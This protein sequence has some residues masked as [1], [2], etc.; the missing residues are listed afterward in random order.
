MSVPRDWPWIAVFVLG[1]GLAVAGQ[2][3]L[4]GTAGR[5]VLAFGLLAIFGAAI[6]FITKGDP[7]PSDER[8]VPAGHSGI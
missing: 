8:R 2:A 5:I 7:T 1:V 6:R 4:G 3:I